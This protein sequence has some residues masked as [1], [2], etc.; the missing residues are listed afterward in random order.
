MM[1]S[2]EII[3]KP[4]RWAPLELFKTVY[5]DDT[6]F[7]KL[8]MVFPGRIGYIYKNDDG[9]VNKIVIAKVW[10]HKFGEGDEDETA[11]F[12]PGDQ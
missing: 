2:E 12:G 7:D 10:P 4:Y 8:D 3:A 5:P 1:C 11:L 9:S 6:E